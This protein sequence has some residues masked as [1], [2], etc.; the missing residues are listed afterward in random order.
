MIK[1]VSEIDWSESEINRSGIIPYF[2]QNG[3]VKLGFPVSTF[4]SNISTIGGVFEPE[5]DY[6]L[7]STAVREFNEE[8]GVNFKKM[9]EKDLYGC[10]A[11]T[12]NYSYTIIYKVEK[13]NETFI[14]TDE[15]YSMIWITP[16]Q[17]EIMVKN[18][19]TLIYK[20]NN[21]QGSKAFHFSRDLCLI[22]ENICYFFSQKE[23][24]LN[25]D[26]SKMLKKN[27]RKKKI[28]DK[29]GRKM[30][31]DYDELKNILKTQVIHT[32]YVSNRGSSYYF[33]IEQ[34]RKILKFKA[35]EKETK[36]VI[37]LLQKCDNKVIYV[38][39]D[40]D[41]RIFADKFGCKI[42]SIESHLTRVK[43]NPNPFIDQV[44]HYRRCN[45][46]ESS[47]EELNTLWETEN[48]VYSMAKKKNSFF[49]KSRANLMKCLL[50]TMEI[51]SENSNYIKY[52]KLKSLVYKKYCYRQP[53]AKWAL[54]IFLKTG[55]IR[56]IITN[57]GLLI[58]TL[59]I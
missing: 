55:I 53:S 10:F 12:N 47:Y 27:L 58:A 44:I 9:S 13:T 15:V 14:R 4:S 3:V 23:M 57:S 48:K 32:S 24:L 46:D 40:V 39:L 54:E 41:Q 59:P 16:R 21:G 28:F 26:P 52:S 17:L 19:D 18:D 56:T 7:L 20:N 30:V 25:N 5:E 35:C 45:N 50:V 8:M 49:N 6:D 34:Y 42:K 22:C 11:I 33:L 38:A 37:K 29:S 51:L 1:P 2:I 31:D 36:N 43:M